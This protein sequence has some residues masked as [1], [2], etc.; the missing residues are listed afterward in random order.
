MIYT[1]QISLLIA[2]YIVSYASHLQQRKAKKT[3]FPWIV[4]LLV[5]NI[6]YIPKKFT[7]QAQ[8]SYP[9]ITQLI[10]VAQVVK[11]ATSLLTWNR[12]ICCMPLVVRL[13]H[14][15]KYDS[16]NAQLTKHIYLP[17]IQKWSTV[18]MQWI[19][20]QSFNYPV[21]T[22]WITISLY[23]HFYTSNFWWY[24]YNTWLPIC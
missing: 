14:G 22:S 21:Y 23:K 1:A 2:F 19:N 4:V 11:V 18:T 13:M 8:P 10:N 16:L 12:K 15:T 5:C 3:T 24:W 9:C 17:C 7:R 20:H 6:Y